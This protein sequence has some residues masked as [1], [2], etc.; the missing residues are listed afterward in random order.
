[1]LDLRHAYH[2]LLGSPQQLALC[3][4]AR[5]VVD[6]LAALRGLW[7]AGGHSDADI[8]QAL[9]ALNRDNLPD[10]VAAG[11][12]GIWLPRSYHARGQHLHW[13]LPD[14]APTEPFHDEYLSRCWQ[15]TTLN[16]LITPRT[17]LRALAACARRVP[18]ARPAGFILHLS[19]CGSTLLSGC[20]SELD[21][22]AVFSES[23]VLTEV[24]VD[25]A[26]S[27]EEKRAGVESLID[28][29]ASLFP[30]R[31]VVIKWN[32]WD[33]FHARMLRS[34]YPTVPIV[35][36][37]RDPVEI[38]ASHHA[39]AGRHMSGDP[40]LAGV[41]PVFVVSANASVL[42]H[43]IRVLHG[44]MEGMLALP[45]EP[46]TTCI[47][48]R[49]LNG[50]TVRQV[51]GMFGLRCDAQGQQRIAQR[52]QRNAKLPDIR[53]QPDRSAKAAVFDAAES[54]AIAQRLSSL[55][56]A[57]VSPAK[58]AAPEPEVANAG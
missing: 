23:P 45:A 54:R 15:S 52:M 24:L 57:L 35:A 51:A 1:M 4:Q 28:V 50:N 7:G 9:D 2:T 41:A 56:R 30:G 18:R 16:Q 21:E 42:E 48:Y 25:P 26:L 31:R 12:A 44:L 39:Q 3:R 5:S 20:L 33:I 55:H 10:E 43:R 6:L 32:A 46:H 29:K 47:D 53:F 22:A 17:S 58:Q 11:M 27:P 14:G 19:R 34:A 36:L 8:L 49:Q 40:S 13:C 37:V 38:L